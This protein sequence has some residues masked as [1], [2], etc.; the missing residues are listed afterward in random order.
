[1]IFYSMYLLSSKTINLLYSG[2]MNTFFIKDRL[3]F[4]KE[5][6]KLIIFFLKSDISI[7]IQII[8]DSLITSINLTAII[9]YLL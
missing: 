5:I 1:M 8:I 9:L 4:I 7:N 3:I 6:N 2:V